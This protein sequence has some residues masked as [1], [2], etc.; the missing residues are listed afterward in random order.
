MM[1]YL[2]IL[3]MLCWRDKLAKSY[4]LLFVLLGCISCVNSLDDVENLVSDVNLSEEIAKEVRILYSDSAL[5]RVIVNAPLLVRSFEK[6]VSVDRFPDGILVEFLND[7]GKPQSWLE[8]DYAEKSSRSDEVIA[9]DN[10]VFYNEQQDKLETSELIWNEASGEVYTD[11]F[12]KISQP[13]KKDTSYGIGFKTNETFTRFEIK[14]Y[15]AI[16]NAD[17]LKKE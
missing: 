14:K 6:S 10:V 5:V 17:I 2:H 16:K 7:N 9:R 4:I 11:K 12:I 13:S 3:G 8:A 1:K 15:Q